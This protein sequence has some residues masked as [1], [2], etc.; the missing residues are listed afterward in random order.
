MKT[1]TIS[2]A[3]SAEID[4]IR[5]RG[6]GDFIPH[7]AQRVREDGF[8]DLDMDDPWVE[9]LA[10]EAR[11]GEDQSAVILRLG[12]KWPREEPTPFPDPAND[13]KLA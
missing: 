8:V 13:A 3:A 12:Q 6:E 4:R 9:A 7:L 1:V 10:N 2:M 11:E 5:A